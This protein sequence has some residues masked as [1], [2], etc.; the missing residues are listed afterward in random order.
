MTGQELL[1]FLREIEETNPDMLSKNIE[2]LNLDDENPFYDLYTA[3]I[4]SKVFNKDDE[5]VDIEPYI[6]LVIE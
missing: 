6:R 1:T 3:D 2:V 4:I 5:F